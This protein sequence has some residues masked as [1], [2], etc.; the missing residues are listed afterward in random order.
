MLI[1]KAQSTELWCDHIAC[2]SSHCERPP[3]TGNAP[4]V[5]WLMRCAKGSQAQNTLMMTEGLVRY[6]SQT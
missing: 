6:N 5:I 1:L 2:A 4:G 3:I